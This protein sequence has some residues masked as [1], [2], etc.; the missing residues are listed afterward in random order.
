MQKAA[1]RLAVNVSVAAA[2]LGLKTAILCALGRDAAGNLVKNTL[3]QHCVDLSMIVES[4]QT[5]VTTMFVNGDG[6]RKSI[7]NEAH[8]Y[9]FHPET[10]RP[11]EAKAVLLGSLFRTP[12]DDPGIIYSI[13]R[14]A[15]QAG[16]LTFADTKLPNFRV[17]APDDLKDSFPLIDYITPE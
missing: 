5:P 9:N 17:I 7:T 14:T 11:A 8:R 13:L 2:K 3:E 4:P 1:H 6:S 10:V 16:Q 15:K 12:F